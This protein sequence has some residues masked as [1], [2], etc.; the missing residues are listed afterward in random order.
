MK[1]L[2]FLPALFLLLVSACEK[3]PKADTPEGALNRYVEAAFGAKSVSDKQKLTDLS[4]GEALE[5]INRMSDAEFKKQFIDTSLSLVKLKSKD[6]RQEE[7]G[8]VSLVYEI[9]FKEGK[10]AQ[11]SIMS[12]KKIAYL[13][14]ADGGWKIKS[15]KNL[16]TFIEQKEALVITP[17]DAPQAE[18]ADKK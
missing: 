9:E 8:D 7:G 10:G 17:N 16:K 6:L 2:N 12:N 11:G 15:T 3:A 4:T 5:Y 14:H 13:T 1:F 18:K